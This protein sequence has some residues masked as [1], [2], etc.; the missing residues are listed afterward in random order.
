MRHLIKH[1][2][3]P[4]VTPADLLSLRKTGWSCEACIY[5]K[6]YKTNTKGMRTRAT[7]IGQLI[8]CDIFGPTQQPSIQ[9]GYRYWITFVD[10]Y[11]RRLWLYLLI[12]RKHAVVAFKQFVSDFA[13]A[14]RGVKHS[15]TLWRT[16]CRSLNT[17]ALTTLENLWVQS[18]NLPLSFG[19]LVSPMSL[20]PR[21]ST[22][23]T[24]SRN[25]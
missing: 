3:L 12:E 18:P 22:N 14:S 10:D 23:R 7:S 19:K 6:P 1:G 2:A 13:A 4:G 5:G 21:T 9:G 15:T 8:H 11:T 16:M 25:E 17:S 24:A 20:V